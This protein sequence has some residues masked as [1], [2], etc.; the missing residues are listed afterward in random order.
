MGISIVAN[1]REN[2]FC[3]DVKMLELLSISPGLKLSLAVVACVVVRKHNHAKIRK[4]E[5]FILS[6]LL[7]SKNQVMIWL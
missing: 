1:F 2:F 7:C 6:P 3:A 4:G 5:S